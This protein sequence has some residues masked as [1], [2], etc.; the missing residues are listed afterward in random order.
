MNRSE[1]FHLGLNPT[2]VAL[3]AFCFSMTIGV[4]WEFL[5][6]GLDVYTNTDTQ[7]D[8]LVRD[9][10]SV[11]LNEDDAN[12]PVEIND[13]DRT[14]IYYEE[15]GEEKSIVVQNGYLD[16][17]LHDTM[18]DMWVNFIGAVVFSVIGVLY[19]KDR[20]GY[21]FAENF[22]PKFKNKEPKNDE[23]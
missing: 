16:I 2:F 19:I 15:D 14:V 20:D 11:Y 8:V 5:E 12:K 21:K 3:V 18:D 17:G 1:K 6:Y 7:K 4:V 13:I 9:I 22:I 23:K 10:A